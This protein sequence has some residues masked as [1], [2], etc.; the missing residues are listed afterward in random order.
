MF[1]KFY[2]YND[3]IGVRSDTKQQ[4]SE[5]IDEN[6]WILTNFSKN[7]SLSKIE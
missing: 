2:T 1:Q 3:K 5:L 6:F 4:K 7:L